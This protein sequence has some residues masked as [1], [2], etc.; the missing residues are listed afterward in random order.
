MAGFG[1]WEEIGRGCGVGISGRAQDGSLG[2]DFGKSP[3]WVIGSGFWEEP[4]MGQWF[5]ILGRA[6]GG[7]L[8]QD[9]GTSRM[10]VIIPLSF[11]LLL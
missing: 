6:P 9:F 3:G 5:G 4:V 10:F 11:L 7:L 8:D 1:F 2:W